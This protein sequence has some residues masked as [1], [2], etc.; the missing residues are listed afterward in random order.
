MVKLKELL[1]EKTYTKG[2]L[3]KLYKEFAEDFAKMYP[4]EL[5]GYMMDLAK[6]PDI[7]DKA[8]KLIDSHKKKLEN[9][10]E[11]FMD[12]FSDMLEKAKK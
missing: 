9:T 4:N 6:Y 11:S 1:T 3:T 8:I 12:K 7:H 2:Q 5:K 10:Y